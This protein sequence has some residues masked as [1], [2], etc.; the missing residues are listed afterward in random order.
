MIGRATS[1]ATEAIAQ[2]MQ[3]PTSRVQWMVRYPEIHRSHSPAPCILFIVRYFKRG[4]IFKLLTFLS[5]L[6]Q[7]A[8]L[9]LVHSWEN[10]T[11]LLSFEP[12]VLLNPINYFMSSYYSLLDCANRLSDRS[13]L[14][15]T[16]NS[17]WRLRSHV[18]QHW[19]KDLR[20]HKTYPCCLDAIS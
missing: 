14:P 1:S 19:R 20:R 6:K 17:A 12:R 16:L 9:R 13:T 10:L 11:T 5:L 3:L 18:C 7:I 15:C 2:A 4:R 8:A